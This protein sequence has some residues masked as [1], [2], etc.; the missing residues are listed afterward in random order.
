M[1][2]I[3]HNEDNVRWDGTRT[4]V[5]LF[6]KSHLC[7]RL[8]AWFNVDSEDLFLLFSAALRVDDG[9]RDLHLFCAALVHIFERHTEVVDNWRVLSVASSH[10][11]NSNTWPTHSATEEHII[12]HSVVHSTTAAHKHARSAAS[13][14]SSTTTEEL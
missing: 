2:A 11:A 7:T 8:P 12:H 10:A 14:P 13:W 4:L 5:S 1:L 9:T 6:R 3:F